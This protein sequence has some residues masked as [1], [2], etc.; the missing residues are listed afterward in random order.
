MKMTFVNLLFYLLIG[1]IISYVSYKYWEQNHRGDNNN[2]KI[3]RKH[4][5]VITRK[6]SWLKYRDEIL[7]RYKNGEDIQSISCDMMIPY[8]TVYNYCILWLWVKKN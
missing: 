1:A 4:S 8:Y 7:Q 3:K 6:Y 5:K 2:P